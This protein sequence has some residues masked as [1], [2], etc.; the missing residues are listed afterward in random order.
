MVRM[1]DPLN[2][3]DSLQEWVSDNE[4]RI[5]DARGINVD[6]MDSEIFERLLKPTPSVVL[7][8]IRKVMPSIIAADIGSGW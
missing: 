7:P 4:Q 2:I 1:V 3:M 8:L 6:V 5:L